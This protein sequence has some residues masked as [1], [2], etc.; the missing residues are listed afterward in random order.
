MFKGLGILPLY[1]W[2]V[3]NFILTV[4]FYTCHTK[5]F[6]KALPSEKKNTVAAH[7]ANYDYNSNSP[8]RGRYIMV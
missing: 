2:G 7:M 8:E 3:E 6:S 1:R 5:Y 4:S